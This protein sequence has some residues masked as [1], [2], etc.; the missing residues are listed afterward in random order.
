MGDP[1]CKH[2]A[3]EDCEGDGIGRVT[4]AGGEPICIGCMFGML[5]ED[6]ST[7]LLDIVG[8]GDW[9]DFNKP[10]RMAAPDLLAACESVARVS[11]GCSCYERCECFDLAIADVHEAIRKAR[12]DG[13]G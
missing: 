9:A 6:P 5:G 13:H 11:A 8:V 1:A 4:V 12:G 2:K 3:A 7:V 10:L